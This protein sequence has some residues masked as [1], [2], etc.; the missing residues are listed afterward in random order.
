MKLNEAILLMV[1]HIRNAFEF[2]IERGSFVINDGKLSLSEKYVA[3]EW[4]AILGSA[5]NDGIYKISSVGSTYSL[6]NGSDNENPVTDEEFTGAVWRLR[7]PKSLVS[8][9]ADIQ[10]WTDS[11]EGKPSNV[12]SESV[13]SFYSK[14]LATTKD[15]APIGW[16]SVFKSRIHGNWRK[17]WETELVRSL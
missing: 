14:T 4:I 8:L 11:P 16:E 9:C 12:V 5:L 1:K 6:A 10:K 15:G 2:S 7:L 13:V 17:M 3:G